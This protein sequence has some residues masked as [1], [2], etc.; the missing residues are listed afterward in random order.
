[1]DNRSESLVSKLV[2]IAMWISML[3]MRFETL[4]DNDL[5]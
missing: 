5:T 2:K 4:F 1:M 3:R